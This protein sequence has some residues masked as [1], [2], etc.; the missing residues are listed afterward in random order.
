MREKGQLENFQEL[1]GWLIANRKDTSYGETLVQCR[2][3]GTEHVE[4]EGVLRIKVRT[5]AIRFII[6]AL[7]EVVSCE[8][9]KPGDW[10]VEPQPTVYRNQ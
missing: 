1:G 6:L 8:P 9:P 2:C 7:T 3:H 5:L 10:G 4:G